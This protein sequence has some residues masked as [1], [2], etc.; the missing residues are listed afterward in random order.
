MK[1]KLQFVMLHVAVGILLFIV[2]FIFFNYQSTREKGSPLAELAGAT[3]PVMEI[4]SESGDYNLMKAYR[5]QIDLSLV[6]NQI[7]I[8]DDSGTLDIKLHCYDYD[9]T[10]IQ[11]SLFKNDPESPLE[12]GTLNQLD[13]GLGDNIRTGSIHFSSDL[14]EGENYFLRMAV[15]LDNSTQAWFY[16]RLQTSQAHYNDYIQFALDFHH[17]LLDKEGASEKIGVY[18]ETDASDTS[19]SLTH[20]DIHSNY[21]SIIYGK[22]SVKEEQD[23]R[24]KIR[25]INNTYAVLELTTV[26]SSEIRSDVIQYYDVREIYKLRY[27]ADRMFLLDYHRYMNARY[28]PEF[29]DSSNNYIGIGIQS[30]DQVDYVSSGDGYKLAFVVEGQ[31]W[32]YDYKSSNVYRV[33]SFTS[34][35]VADLRNDQDEHGIRILSMDDDGNITYLVYGYMSRG[36]HEGANGIQ[37][38]QYDVKEN[39]N[40]EVAFLVTSLP[41]STMIENLDKLSYLNKDRHFYCLLD[42]DLHDIDISKKEDK[43]LHSGLVNESLTASGDGNVIAV[44]KDK[45]LTQN[46]EIVVTDLDN[47][48]S[49][50]FSC[51]EESRICAVGFLNNDFIYAEGKA[52]DISKDESGAVTFPAESLH[53]M[54]L[55]GTQ[56]RQYKKAGR[57]VIDARVSGSVLEMDFAKKSGNSFVHTDDRDYIRYKEEESTRVA[58]TSKQS[59]TFGEQLYFAF[60][61]YVYIQIAPDLLLTKFKTSDDDKTLELSRNQEEARQ[62][63]VYAGGEKKETF[64]NLPDAI[65]KASELR[66]NVF[67]NSEHKIWECA[68]DEYNIVPGMDK[69]IKVDSDQMS[70]AGC[71][72]MIATVN[73]NKVTPDE[74]D[75]KPGMPAALLELCTNEKTLTLTGCSLDDVLYY[76]SQGS[77][78]LARYNETRYVVVMS[79]NSTKVRYLDPVTGKSTVEDRAQITDTFRKEGN[80][81]YSYLAE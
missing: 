68:F 15:R 33:Y 20:V 43:I 46:T 31:L 77:P 40:E 66:G 53:I 22:M 36:H 59:E 72:S 5:G 37:I 27:T 30:A 18:L 64:T 41:Y 67:D 51:G 65:I 23:P 74:I 57:Y 60:P 56:V 47:G 10:A 52:E 55:E 12:E 81:F 4:T 21:N 80:I 35:N 32:Y 44:E 17:T 79:Y 63:Y 1:Q 48:L 39:Y 73:G 49:H 3:Y 13:D 29:I 26:L 62:Y 50:S 76:V 28:N 45:D 34:E 42:G 54:N 11:Y 2:S 7:S 78:V 25:E 58:L 8:L 75:R 9:I 6:R 69:V 16:S 19:Y 24:I 14:K 71:L 61:D 70:L 38:L